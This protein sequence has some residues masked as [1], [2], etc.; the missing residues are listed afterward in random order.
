MKQTSSILRRFTFILLTV[1]L[2]ACGHT[3]VDP[4]AEEANYQAWQRY[5]QAL[6]G[7]CQRNHGD[8]VDACMQNELQQ[9]GLPA[10][11][12]DDINS[13]AIV[14]TSPGTSRVSTTPSTPGTDVRVRGYDR[15]DGTYVRPHTRSAPRR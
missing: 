5:A 15:K 14:P 10:T 7:W 3:H 9:K 8:N 13:P 6:R 12:I 4:G 1:Y 11:L 2:S